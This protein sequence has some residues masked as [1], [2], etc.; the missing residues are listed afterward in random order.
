MADERFLTA[1]DAIYALTVTDLFTSAQI[2]AGYSTDRAF[3]T[4]AVEAVELQMGV[5]GFLSGGYVPKETPQ[6]I[7]FQSDSLSVDIFD[8]WYGQQQQNR[9]LYRANATVIIPA[10]GKKYTLRKGFLSSWVPIPGTGKI[11][12]A[13]PARITW[14]RIT[15]APL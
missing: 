12:A 6:T 4:D 14:E 11:L 10:I 9:Q 7:T 2:L 15:V 3:E 8:Y 5:D 13:R 1:A